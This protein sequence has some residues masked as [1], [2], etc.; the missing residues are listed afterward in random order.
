MSLKNNSFGEI[1][2]LSGVQKA[3]SKLWFKTISSSDLLISITLN[4][5]HT[6]YTYLKRKWPS[7]QAFLLN[8]SIRIEGGNTHSILY[9]QVSP[10]EYHNQPRNSL[11]QKKITLPCATSVS[12]PI[13]FFFFKGQGAASSKCFIQLLGKIN[14][15]CVRN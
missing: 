7:R 11:M 5:L 1:K 9:G 14:S 12:S 3:I 15:E 13:N 8:H 10:G 2:T 6:V 4:K